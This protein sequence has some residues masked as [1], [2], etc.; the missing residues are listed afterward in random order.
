[1]QKILYSP[2]F[3]LIFVFIFLLVV[4]YSFESRTYL[5]TYFVDIGHFVCF[6][7]VSCLAATWEFPTMCDSKVY[8]MYC[9]LIH[10]HSL[11]MRSY[12]WHNI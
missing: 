10:K 5:D 2:T 6:H 12:L 8:L 7:V 3:Q 9:N 1:M 11:Y 4:F